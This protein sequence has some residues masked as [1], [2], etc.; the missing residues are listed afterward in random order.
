[1]CAPLPSS[2][3]PPVR[4][5]VRSGAGA[6]LVAL[7][8][9]LTGLLVVGAGALVA[10]PA[11]AQQVPQLT[12]EINDEAGLLTGRE[13]EVRAALAEL[14]DQVHLFVLTTDTTAATPVTSFVQEVASENSLGGDDALLLVAIDDRSYALWVADGLRG[15][16]D[17][18][19]DRI[20]TSVVEPLLAE[21]D[22]AGAAIAAG[23]ALADAQAGQT[24]T[25]ADDDPAPTDP[26]PAPTTGPGGATGG[27]VPWLLVIPIAAFVL[28]AAASRLTE[29]QG[30]RRSSE[31][32][33]RRLGE[34]ARS[35]NARLLACDEAVREATT[36]LAFAEARFHA[37]DVAPLRAA[38]DTARDA[39]HDAFELRQR[40][41]DEVLETPLERE[42]LLQRIV[43]HTER[44]DGVLAAEY[45]RLDDLRELEQEAPRLL[46]DLEADI[47]DA[48]T[49]REAAGPLHERLAARSATAR[50]ATRGNLTEADKRL[51][52]AA[53]AVD[54]GQAALTGNETSTAARAVR[55][56]QGAL[57]A[58]Q[59]LLLAVEHAASELDEAE[60]ELD[61]ALRAAAGALDEATAAATDT[62]VPTPAPARAPSAGRA[63]GGAGTPPPP[64]PPSAPALVAEARRLLEHARAARD[65]DPLRAYEQARGAESAA[66]QAVALAHAAVERRER[67]TTAARAALRTA[68]AV[69]D[70]AADYLAV[71][72]QGV[73]RE[74]RTRIQ[75]A[76]RHLDRARALLD[77]DPAT[78]ADEAREAE[79]L[80]A[81]AYRLASRDFDSY[82]QYRGPFGR[83][84][85]GGGGGPTIVIGGFPIPLGGS[86]RGGGGFGG[87]VWGSP[88]GRST[89]GVFGGG[90]GFGGGFG[91]GGR[92]MGGG[93]GGGGRA[94]GGRF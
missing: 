12:D 59:Q 10:P 25:P 82:D 46:D 26:T 86:R 74:A 81:E 41:D 76:E 22:F 85:Y 61:T 42:Q 52:A 11:G 40:L 44:I 5:A 18:D 62:R 23:Q 94:G 87:S 65:D 21:G 3:V 34:L 80:A 6:R 27:Q 47:R 53:A 9:L 48:R 57:A 84:P 56:A 93:F 24:G 51:A 55:E 8:T 16:S 4:L 49:R 7:L 37:D 35:A 67:E 13:D 1:M 38:L 30:R 20:N 77:T 69:Y 54:A 39:L 66:V 19:I 75:E 79:R 92:S 33:D 2:A 58:A 73:G 31:E 32:R 64:P 72:R 89:G 68:T 78:A 17:T 90:R 91:G 14:R 71:R 60:R 83:G 29:R 63:R 43:E 28:F 45:A 70:R 15:V 36:E 88:G 50:D